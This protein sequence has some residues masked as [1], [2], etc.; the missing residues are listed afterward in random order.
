MHSGNITTKFGRPSAS[1]FPFPLVFPPAIEKILDG[2][3]P[4]WYSI[5]TMRHIVKVD[6]TNGMFRIIIPHE[7]IKLKR[8]RDVKRVFVDSQQTDVIN[9]RRLVDGKALKTDDKRPRT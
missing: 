2:I 5:F 4:T 8:W 1:A 3:L 7:L 9:I 6:T